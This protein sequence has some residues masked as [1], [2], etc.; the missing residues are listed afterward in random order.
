MQIQAAVLLCVLGMTVGKFSQSTFK[1]EIVNEHN[2]KRKGEPARNMK[3]MKW[4]DKLA[5]YGQAWANKCRF[6]HGQPSEAKGEGPIGQNLYASWGRGVTHVGKSAVKAWFGEKNDY[7]F[8]SMK[9]NPGKMCGHYTQVVW[10]K[11][12]EVGCGYKHCPDGM[13]IVVCNYQPAGNYIGEHPY[14]T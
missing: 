11:S 8:S 2:D 9:C 12:T 10:A 6:A 4:S 1:S 5:G 14:E 13:D 3:M 7:H